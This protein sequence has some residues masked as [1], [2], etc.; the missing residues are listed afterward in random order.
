MNQNKRIIILSLVLI[1][2]VAGGL[3]Y[4]SRK[5]VFP[6]TEG[7]FSANAY[8]E[9]SSG[10]DQ[11][12][13][14]RGMP[15]EGFPKDMPIDPD[16]AEILESYSAVSSNP[17]PK[18]GMQWTYSYA[19]RLSPEKSLTNF[20][21]YALSK[22]FTIEDEVREENLHSLYATMGSYQFLN[23]VMAPS[24]EI[25]DELRVVTISLIIRPS[26]KPLE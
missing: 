7:E 11:V 9:G 8:P 5:S 20:K 14:F 24:I 3:F 23:V 18:D 15:P 16:P 4:N 12:K 19:T 2:I 21:N 25:D 22:K 10:Q 1:A 17:P 6:E 26:Q 13:H